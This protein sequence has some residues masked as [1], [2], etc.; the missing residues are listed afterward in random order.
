MAENDVTG[1]LVANN[2]VAISAHFT[3]ALKEAN[4]FEAASGVTGHLVVACG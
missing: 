4:D 3:Q 1:N 2:F